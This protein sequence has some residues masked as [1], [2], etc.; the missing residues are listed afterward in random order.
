MILFRPAQRTCSFW[1]ALSTATKYQRRMMHGTPIGKALCA[2]SIVTGLGIAL[3]WMGFYTVGLA[4][5]DPP[6][7]YLTFEHSFPPADSLLATALVVGGILAARKNAIGPRLLSAG[8]GALSFLGLLDASFNWQNGMYWIS[9]QDGLLNG[10]INLWCLAF[11]AVLAVT[12]S[13][14]PHP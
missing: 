8:G 11:G 4:P 2:L 7:C 14:S 13:R 3:F 10:I 9:V 6:T 5:K 1:L 12:A